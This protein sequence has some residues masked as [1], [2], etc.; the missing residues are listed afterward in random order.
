[1]GREWNQCNPR[2]TS[3]SVNV[4]RVL[5]IS[6]AVTFCSYNENG[7]RR[8]VR[9]RYTVNGSSPSLIQQCIINAITFA[10][11]LPKNNAQVANGK[12]PEQTAAQIFLDD[13]NKMLSS[14]V[15]N[16]MFYHLLSGYY[17]P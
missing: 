16:L 5:L 15:D 7:Q 4:K 2:Y 3:Q 1:M 12:T 14:A 8:L 10:F 13:S 17:I 9:K 6:A 11:P